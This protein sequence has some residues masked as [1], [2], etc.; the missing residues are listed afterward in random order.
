[1]A[2][3]ITSLLCGTAIFLLGFFAG[4]VFCSHFIRMICDLCRPEDKDIEDDV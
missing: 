4:M 2:M 1:M 3:S